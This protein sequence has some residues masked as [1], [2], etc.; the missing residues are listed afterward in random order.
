MGVTHA[1]LVE[2]D[3][4]DKVQFGKLMTLR[5][6][7]PKG[8]VSQLIWGDGEGNMSTF[9][10]GVNI[11]NARVAALLDAKGLRSAFDTMR[12]EINA[13]SGW[14]GTSIN[15]AIRDIVKNYKPVFEGKGIKLFYCGQ[16]AGKANVRHW[17]E[18]V[19]TAV[20]ED[21]EYTPDKNRGKNIFGCAAAGFSFV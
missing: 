1:K 21:P 6:S 11:P 3:T 10:Y 2:C 7:L 20:C 8:I 9:G 15:N 13:V 17:F 18:Y 5:K 12:K 16:Y 19:D 14:N 4:G